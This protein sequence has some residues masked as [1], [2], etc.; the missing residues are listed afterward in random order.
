ML[1]KD[2]LERAEALFRMRLA[3]AVFKPRALQLDVP[4]Q[5][6]NR[7]VVMPLA[8][9]YLAAIR[10]VAPPKQGLLDLLLD[11]ALLDRFQDQLAFRQGE[12]ESL[13]RHLIAHDA[14]H[15]L[16]VLVA[17]VVHCHQLKSEYDARV[18]I[19]RGAVISS[20]H[21]AGYKF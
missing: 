7:D 17:G 21:C 16:D 2:S 11:Y 9:A 4:K 15:F 1:G 20:W 8:V 19:A 13:H 18:P 12:A 6:A 3:P 10:A 14:R 5:S